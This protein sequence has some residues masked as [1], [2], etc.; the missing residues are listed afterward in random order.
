M[1]TAEQLRKMTLEETEKIL[2]NM[3]KADIPSIKE[4]EPFNVGIYDEDGHLI[5]EKEGGE[6]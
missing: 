1:F 2:R 4:L 5:G 3:P 6:Y